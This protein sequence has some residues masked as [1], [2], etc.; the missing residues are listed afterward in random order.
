MKVQPIYHIT[1]LKAF[2]GG[3]NY[4]GQFDDLAEDI[5]KAELAILA[6][7]QKGKQAVKPIEP[8]IV[9]PFT[10]PPF[11]FGEFVEQEK[12]YILA[13]IER[14]YPGFRKSLIQAQ[15]RKLSL[16]AE[17]NPDAWNAAAYAPPIEAAEELPPPEPKKKGRG[18]KRK[19]RKQGRM[20]PIEINGVPYPSVAEAALQTGLNYQYIRYQI[21]LQSETSI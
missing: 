11:V 17:Q 5:L 7:K 20:R 10:T 21:N 14:K 8:K 1:E 19:E 2:Q 3:N 16:L 15:L 18:K 9:A 13:E 4:S 6:D 12:Q